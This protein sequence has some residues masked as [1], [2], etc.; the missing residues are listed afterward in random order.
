MMR[1]FKGESNLHLTFSLSSLKTTLTQGKTFMFR[2]S[3]N[4][5]NIDL[6]GM[7]SHML[8]VPKFD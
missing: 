2:K 7:P 1:M 6:G 5:S 3:D 8:I 4:N